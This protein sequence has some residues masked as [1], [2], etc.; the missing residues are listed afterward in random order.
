MNCLSPDQK[1]P[2]LR[3]KELQAAQTGEALMKQ[4]PMVPPAVRRGPGG[5]V[6]TPE[7]P[8]WLRTSIVHRYRSVEPSVE[9]HWVPLCQNRISM[10]SCRNPMWPDGTRR[11]PM[12][13][14]TIPYRCTTD[15]REFVDLV[16]FREP[17]LR[18]GRSERSV[19]AE[20]C[21]ERKSRF[22]FF[23]QL[24]NRYAHQNCT[25]ILCKGVPSV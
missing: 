4:G 21:S 8:V 22:S 2:R 11:A 13:D 19:H 16:Y 1:Y 10:E 18:S 17:G 7:G 14:S 3:Q 20:Q 24:A 15:L 6:E 12:E 25:A 23:W 5:P 9:P